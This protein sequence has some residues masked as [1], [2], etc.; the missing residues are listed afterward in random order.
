MAKVFGNP[1]DLNKMV[2]G[3]SS[4]GQVK[5]LICR[6]CGNA[7]RAAGSPGF[8]PDCGSDS[9]PVVAMID[10]SQV[11]FEEPVTMRQQD[12]GMGFQYR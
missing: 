1:G 4:G 5:G 6:K 8:C 11:P 9:Y 2:A 7:W 3:G 10:A 12:Y